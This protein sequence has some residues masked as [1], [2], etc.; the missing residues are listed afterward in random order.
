MS[1][2]E[3]YR[4]EIAALDHEIRHYAAVCRVSPE[5]RGELEVFLRQTQE[6]AIA[7][8]ARDTL[9]GLLALRLRLET[10]MISLGYEVPEF[11][12]QNRE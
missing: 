8:Q 7:N 5:N 10:E 4:Q 11:S 12:T 6:N 9:R 1:G 2:F 3:H